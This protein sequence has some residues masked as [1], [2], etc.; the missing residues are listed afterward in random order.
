M[1]HSSAVV[2]DGVV[3]GSG[4]KV[5]HWCHIE[6]GAVIGDDTSIGQCCY[7]GKGVKIGRR[8]RIQNGVNVFSGVTI[9]DDCFIGPGVQFTNVRVPVVGMKRSGNWDEIVV[10]DE[11]VIGAGS[12]IVAP[13]RVY[14]GTF[15]GAGSV[16]TKDV[17]GMVYGN[18]AREHYIQHENGT[19]M[20]HE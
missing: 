14:D 2:E 10:G 18:P 1:V 5:W 6:S 12:V 9:G 20:K 11:V 13:C 15:I 4:V 16:V 3:M 17:W 19:W 7:V 8:C